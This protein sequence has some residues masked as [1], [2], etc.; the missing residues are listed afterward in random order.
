[1]T[2]QAISRTSQTVDF[3]AYSFFRVVAIILLVLGLRYWGLLVGV[4]DEGI[5]FDTMENHWRVVSTALSVLLPVA[6]LGMW[7]LHNW[8]IAIWILVVVT[9]LFMHGYMPQL[10][11]E[12]DFL[13]VFHATTLVALLI[14]RAILYQREAVKPS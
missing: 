9:E 8:G 7:G 13:I 5:R 12:A 2:D 6:A 4:I 1:M 14:Y 11:G 3:V 10:F